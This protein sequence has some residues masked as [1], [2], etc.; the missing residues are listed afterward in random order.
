MKALANGPIQLLDLSITWYMANIFPSSFGGT[1][2]LKRT[3]AKLDAAA[4][5]NPKR[6]AATTNSAMVSILT[7]DPGISPIT[8][9]K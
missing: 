2:I 5:L 1:I 9:R 3:R 8:L 6:V 4:R 7:G